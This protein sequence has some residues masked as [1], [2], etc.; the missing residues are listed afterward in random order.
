M[1]KLTMREAMIAALIARGE[2]EVKTQSSKF[3]A[4]TATYGIVRMPSGFTAVIPLHE[5]QRFYF[6]SRR[7]FSLR[8]GANVTGSV[9]IRR[10]AMLALAAEGG[11]K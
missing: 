5:R 10:G 3:Q 11:Y 2:K 6:I 7:G 1:A 9:G 4:F 8:Y